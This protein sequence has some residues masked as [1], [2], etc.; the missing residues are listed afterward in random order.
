MSL[1]KLYNKNLYE[2]KWLLIQGFTHTH[3]HKKKKSKKK[4][5]WTAFFFM[6]GLF[7]DKTRYAFSS[8]SF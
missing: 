7:H 2:K 5:I 1:K 4:G 8:E 6:F 3:T